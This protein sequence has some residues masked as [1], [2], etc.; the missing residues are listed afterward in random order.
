MKDLCKEIKQSL[1][2]IQKLLKDSQN[3]DA[4]PDKIKVEAKKLTRVLTCYK[5]LIN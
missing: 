3:S 1:I 4:L 5:I 2:D